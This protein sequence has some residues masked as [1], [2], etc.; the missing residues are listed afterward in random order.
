[1]IADRTA[2][3]MVVPGQ[4]RG[5][6][7]CPSKNDQHEHQQ[8]R[9]RRGERE[10]ESEERKERERKKR[11][12][13]MVEQIF[14]ENIKRKAEKGEERK[15]EKDIW[16][17]D[18][19]R[20]NPGQHKSRER[21]EEK[22]E[23]KEKT[24]QTKEKE[25]EKEREK[26]ERL[27]KGG[28]KATQGGGVIRDVWRRENMREDPEQQDEEEK[29]RE[30][31]IRKIGE[32]REGKEKEKKG[33][34]P[35]RWGKATQEG[36]AIRNIWRSENRRSNPRRRKSREREEEKKEGERKIRKIKEE[37]EEGEGKWDRLI[38]GRS[39]K[40]TKRMQ[41]RER[42]GSETGK[43]DTNVV[44]N[45]KNKKKGKSGWKME[46]I[47]GNNWKSEEGG[48]RQ[49]GEEEKGEE[50]RKRGDDGKGREGKWKGWWEERKRE[51]EKRWE[52]WRRDM[53]KEKGGRRGGEVK[54]K[55]SREAR[56][57]RRKKREEGR[58]EAKRRRKKREEKKKKEKKEKKQRKEEDERREE[59]KWIR[60]EQ[61]KGIGSGMKSRQPR[62]EMGRREE[63]T[64][65]NQ[66]QKKEYETWKIGTWNLQG[67]RIFS[68]EG[69]K[70]VERA[71]EVGKERGWELLMLSEMG[72]GKNRGW[73]EIAGWLVIFGG[74]VALAMN[75]DWEEAW[76]EEGREWG[77]GE[78]WVWIRARGIKWVSIYAPQS[79]RKDKKERREFWGE[80][81]G[82][83]RNEKEIWIG[84]DM[85]AQIGKKEWRNRRRREEGK[86]EEGQERVGRGK[87]GLEET[88]KTGEELRI[89]CEEMEMEVVSRHFPQRKRG[90]WW[91]GRHKKWYELDGF[92]GKN[93]DIRKV[94][95]CRTI[96]VGLGGGMQT[97]H[98]PKELVG[99]MEKKKSGKR[100]ERRRGRE[101]E[102]E[103]SRE[104]WEIWKPTWRQLRALREDKDIGEGYKEEV[105][106]GMERKKPENWGEISRVV[107]EAAWKALGGE[108]EEPGGGDKEQ[109]W[110]VG[111]KEEMKIWKKEEEKIIK[112][113][114][115]AKEGNEKTGEIWKKY[116]NL[117]KEKKEKVKKW[118]EEWWEEVLKEL[119]IESKGMKMGGVYKM[120]KVLGRKGQK[121]KKV[122]MWEFTV[123]SAREHFAKTTEIRGEL[124]EEAIEKVE[125]REEREWLGKIP[126]EE[127]IVEAVK[128]MRNSAPGEDG[129]RIE[130]FKYGPKKLWEWL[131]KWV[132]E[133]WMQEE[134]GWE[135]ELKI[136][137]QIP[138]FKGKGERSN[139]T[140]YRA[141]TLLS[142]GTRIIA[143]I[144]ASR[145][146]KWA[147]EEKL[148]REEQ[149]G[150][151]KERGTREAIYIMRRI[152]EEAK[153]TKEE[154]IGVD[155]T[156]KRRWT[157][158]L[159][160]LKK[161]Y[162][163]TQR[164]MLW[165]TLE[166]LGVP[167]G[168]MRVLKILHERTRCKIRM[169]REE[170]TE[171][172]PV[173]GLREGC[174]SSPV[175]FNIFHDQVV[176]QIQK[177]RKRRLKE[178][179]EKREVGVVWRWRGE[180]TRRRDVIW[181]Q[182][183]KKKAF[184]T[185]KAEISIVL[186]ADDT[187]IVG[188]KG[189][190]EKTGEWVEQ[191]MKK[192]GEAENEDKREW[193]L[194][195]E[196]N[197]KTRVLGEWLGREEGMKR[198]ME[199]GQ[200][201]WGKVKEWMRYSNLDWKWKGRVMTA[202]VQAAMLYVME[203]KAWSK[204]E[205]TRIQKFLDMCYRWLIRTNRMEMKRRGMKM[206]EIRKRMGVW[207]MKE[208]I[209]RRSL[210]WAGK[211]MKMRKEKGEGWWIGRMMDGWMERE[212][213]ESKKKERRGKEWW[214]VEGWWRQ[215]MRK[216]GWEWKDLIE[217]EGEG[218][219]KLQKEESSKR[220]ML[221][222]E[223]E[224]GKKKV[225]I[226]ERREGRCEGC[227]KRWEK[228]EM[229]KRA[230]HDT[231]CI[232]LRR[233]EGYVCCW[234]CGKKCKTPQARG[235]HEK[236]CKK[237]EESKKKGEG[238]RSEQEEEIIWE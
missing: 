174:P 234:G 40:R 7:A 11:R 6:L 169:G 98:L 172:L 156:E 224:E 124:N 59:W 89:W 232:T 209:A 16:R 95:K 1:M 111:K 228:G 141:I 65:R 110:L 105:E 203:T 119:E 32:E 13:R 200:K 113:W 133:K 39:Q 9:E 81:A 148:L 38:T 28:E 165:A 25:K 34:S 131:I 101:E 30:E 36:E 162:P 26:E 135:E 180:G 55:R 155:E 146:L 190:V 205:I 106:R 108:E 121:T 192:W 71:I 231:L 151:R 70:K 138:I 107:K 117:K 120:M 170:S 8:E 238:T 14:I 109:P 53:E 193:I 112:E 64:S 15:R 235:S 216:R 230:G 152:H 100:K 163:S 153:E 114:R 51:V 189:E 88:T 199:R 60:G 196:D 84:G 164:D 236:W 157:A 63:G 66:S 226:E 144:V 78:R 159:L 19:S 22:K 5:S 225:K 167:Q 171:Y 194:L 129:V 49:E 58:K 99:R 75:K 128:K 20:N 2:E 31:K 227:G 48:E 132:R 33:Q 29:G 126:E 207:N 210:L 198:R 76:R 68:R 143:R 181:T 201:A 104:K 179:D 27:P 154:E 47:K 142:M 123:E 215:Q 222:R 211:I 96:G 137:V 50:D 45:E 42:E 140:N 62:T 24:K 97:D 118:E 122:G 87:W 212:E 37:S 85:N 67:Q 183:M 125:R 82:L 176:E 237:R 83:I 54:R 86:R 178:E 91:S 61:E 219:K 80:V 77:A 35:K 90:T 4:V 158:L 185:R 72:G 10:E 182:K 46:F 127:E 93:K 12:M 94:K 175:L 195:G 184:E 217:D 188:E 69:R 115:R 73:G 206:I 161:A 52:E 18:E 160:D 17:S 214:T 79:G 130:W 223:E 57:R 150:F 3:G 56:E 177:E 116:K 173:R 41:E 166:K 102:E 103:I 149:F 197:D 220:L 74:E 139:P 221:K 187:T 213:K 23:K 202:S 168:I 134:E 204:G 186:F 147:E 233:E 208:V 136:G 145:L 218:W 43:E 44:K 229:R 21:E 191:I 92:L